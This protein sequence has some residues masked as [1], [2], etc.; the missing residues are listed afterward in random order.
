MST[1]VSTVRWLLKKASRSV[2]AKGSRFIK[3]TFPIEHGARTIKVRAL[4]YH[5]F[6]DIAQDPF[7][8]SAKEFAVQMQI[9][10][11]AGLAISLTQLQSFLEGRIQLPR[12]AV[13]VTV[14]DGYRSLRTVALPILQQ[15]AIPAVAFVS[16]G[17]IGR[18]RHQA[19]TEVE[20]YLTWKD[21]TFLA[22]HG[23]NVQSHGWSHRSLPWLDPTEAR[24][25]LIFSKDVLDRRIG[26]VTAFAYPFGTRADFNP[27]VATMVEQAGY[28]MGFTSQHGP[29][30]P[31]DDCLTLNRT[32][33]ERGETEATFSSL[34][35]G[36]LDAWRWVD[37]ALWRIQ[38][39]RRGQG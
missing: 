9:I 38:A 25:E 19:P 20:D 29:I 39:S 7:C 18:T 8:V 23:L 17:M 12:D 6:G 2:V 32:K 24:N 33:V 21:V 5:R 4:T 30:C 11:R 14:D 15:F 16:P 35:H 28:Q 34:V 1:S 10:A 26:A 31:G 37:R 3:E 13:L 22:Q 27:D 36:G